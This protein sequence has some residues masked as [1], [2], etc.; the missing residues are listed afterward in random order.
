MGDTLDDPA[1]L[2]LAGLENALRRANPAVM[3]LPTWL[4]ENVIAADRGLR[5]PLFTIPHDR[6]HV[7]ARERL[8]QLAN[9]EDLPLPGDPPDEPRL[10]LVAR[11][12]NDYLANSP[13]RQ[14]LLA[15]WRLLFHATVD[16]ILWAK[17]ADNAFD[18]P[19][20]QQRIE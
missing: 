3:L 12:D 19:T 14:V 2:D 13:A 11:P 17:R 5:G 1:Q 6:S 4:L 15:F 16:E 10:I 20:V 8:L 9:D 18:D 7:I